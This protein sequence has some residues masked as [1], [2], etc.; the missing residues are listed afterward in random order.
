VD[1]SIVPK[2]LSELIKVIYVD[3][4]QQSMQTVGSAV[5]SMLKFVMLPFSCLGMT[6]DEIEMRYKEF[7]IK[8]LR[9]V[10]P[11][12]LQPPQSTIAG[13]IFEHVKYLFND[14]DSA[15]LEEM[16]SGLLASSMDSTV[17]NNVHPKFVGIIKQLNKDDALLLKYFFK[18]NNTREFFI[19]TMN[20]INLNEINTKWDKQ[21]IRNFIPF[22][23][24]PSNFEHETLL[25]SLEN[26][27]NLS[28]LEFGDKEEVINY[29]EHK[30]IIQIENDV[31]QIEMIQKN[32]KFSKW[33][34][35]FISYVFKE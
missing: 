13:Q 16:F 14:V 19:I 20:Y 25:F 8:T 35:M 17:K 21:F 27:M 1:I 23:C 33:G 12:K 3:T 24:R 9:K 28:L 6:V 32:I 34:K 10:E 22:E 5:N 29:N 31:E 18:E 15:L 11:D 4:T 2:E 26:L 30:D 7:I